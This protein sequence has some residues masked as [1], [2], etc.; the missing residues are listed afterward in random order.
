MTLVTLIP[1]SS[2]LGKSIPSVVSSLISLE[3]SDNVEEE[4]GGRARGSRLSVCREF[5]CQLLFLWKLRVLNMF[6]LF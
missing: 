6:Q 1:H 4:D 5:K 2:R 3:L